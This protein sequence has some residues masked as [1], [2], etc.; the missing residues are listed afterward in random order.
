M[1]DLTSLEMLSNI[2]GATAPEAV[3]QLFETLRKAETGENGGDLINLLSGNTV[4]TEA[5]REDIAVDTSAAEKRL[6][7]DNFPSEKNNFLIV[8]KVMDE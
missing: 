5:L 8:P 2:E 6:I 4:S 3:E 7:I 1:K